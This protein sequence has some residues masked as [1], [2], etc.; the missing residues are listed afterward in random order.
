MA[1]HFRCNPQES[2]FVNDKDE[3]FIRKDI[4]TYPCPLCRRNIGGTLKLLYGIRCDDN[5]DECDKY[6]QC[7]KNIMEQRFY[8][9]LIDEHM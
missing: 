8:Y 2:V 5:P 7:L 1:E 6:H 9:R 3:V 4:W